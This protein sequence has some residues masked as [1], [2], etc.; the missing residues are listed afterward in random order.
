MIEKVRKL[1]ALHAGTKV[2]GECEALRRAADPIRERRAEMRGGGE[3]EEECTYMLEDQWS[4]KLFVALCRRDVLKPYRERG[5]RHTTVI[6][7]MP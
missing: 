4:R 6:V 2:D 5:P 7:R 1:E 3:Q